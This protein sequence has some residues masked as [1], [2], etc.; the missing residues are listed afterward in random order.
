MSTITTINGSDTITSSRTVINTNFSNLNADKIE[1]S[2]LDTDSALTANSDTKIASQKAIKAY[3]DALAPT[4]T[5]S[6]VRAKQ[7]AGVAVGTS[8]ASVAFQAEDFDTSSYHDNATNNTRLTVP[9]GKAGK[10]MITGSFRAGNSAYS[11]ASRIL[12]NG[13]TSIA[14]ASGGIV[15]VGICGS[16]VSVIYDLA[17]SDYVEFQALC[18]TAGNNTSGDQETFFGMYRIG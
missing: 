10:Y 3:V 1:T 15:A 7:N 17:V 4:L 8:F 14:F 2:V 16:A 11:A 13:A 18:G 9:A 6:G 5:F 12:L